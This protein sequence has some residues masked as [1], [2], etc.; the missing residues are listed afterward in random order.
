MQ[1]FLFSYW[2]CS[3]IVPCRVAR[4]CCFR[5]CSRAL[6]YIVYVCD[7][8]LR[9][10]GRREYSVFLSVIERVCR[11]RRRCPCAVSLAAGAIA[12]GPYG[13]TRGLP[14]ERARRESAPT[15]AERFRL[16]GRDGSRPLRCSGCACA[17]CVRCV[18]CVMRRRWRGVPVP[19]TRLFRFCL[20]FFIRSLRGFDFFI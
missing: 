5:T 9:R 20:S 6:S 3:A 16:R 12:I 2:M 19:A 11:P 10:C 7:A 8:G 14:L 18:C 15:V 13:D 17:L 1:F 4:C